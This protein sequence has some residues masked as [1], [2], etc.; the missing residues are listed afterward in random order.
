MSLDEIQSGLL[1]LYERELGPR[2]HVRIIDLTRISDG[3]ETDVYAFV[4]KHGK[5]GEQEREPLILRLYPG[6]A[7]ADKS[8]REFG[9]MLKLYQ[10]G[11]PV[12]QVLRLER[13]DTVFGKPFVIM[14]RIQGRPMGTVVDES[15]TEKKLELLAL[16]CR[17]FVDLHALDWHPFAP[18]SPPDGMTGLSDVVGSEL[19][20]WQDYL[21]RVQRSEFS[22]IFDWLREQLPGVPFGQ[23]SVVHGDYHPW[24]ILLQ[25][26]GT[27][28]VI[29]WT[30]AAVSDYRVDL[31]WTLLLMSTYGSAEP[32]ELVLGEYGRIAGLKIEQIEFFDVMACLRRLAT[33]M[34]SLGSGADRL[35]MRP[36]AEAMMKDAGHIESVY[37]LLRER[38]RISIPAI[39]ELLSSLRPP[40][41]H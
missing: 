14:E 18:A 32:R 13:E 26:D 27:A 11:Y 23:P 39:D 6:D 38:T 29:D 30:N 21:R 1:S 34:I 28:Y 9:V 41:Q 12:P 3:W 25:E 36:G 35:G 5:L 22:P 7:A 19:S 2:E 4:V 16:F 20:Q 17:M 10:A 33:I 40:G 8:A 37:A 24:N 31:A 15:P